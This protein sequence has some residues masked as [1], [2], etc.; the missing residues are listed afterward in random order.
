MTHLIVL[1][2]FLSGVAP[3]S[4]GSSNGLPITLCEKRIRFF[5]PGVYCEVVIHLFYFAK[6]KISTA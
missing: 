6:E 1:D 5:F 3:S 4:S 2:L